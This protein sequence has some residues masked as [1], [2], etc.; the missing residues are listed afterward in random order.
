MGEAEVRDT[1]KIS[2]IGTIARCMVTS[3]KSLETPV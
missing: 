3:G 2:R 1:F